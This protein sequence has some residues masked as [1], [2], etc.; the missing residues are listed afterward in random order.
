MGKRPPVPA[1][2]A[3]KSSPCRHSFLSGGCRCALVGVPWRG[4][5]SARL[6][7]GGIVSFNMLS[8]V[9]TILSIL[10]LQGTPMRAH[11]QLPAYFARIASVLKLLVSL[12]AVVRARR[13]TPDLSKE[14]WRSETA[15]R[16]CR[17]P[18]LGARGMLDLP[19]WLDTNN[20]NTQHNIRKQ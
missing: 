2:Q 10:R 14:A 16:H 20:H 19:A 4:S 1:R 12:V 11:L 8:K 6:A 18:E 3:R 9:Q 5:V 17:D 7:W 15:R 13:D